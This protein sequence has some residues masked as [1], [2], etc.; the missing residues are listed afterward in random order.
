MTLSI[1]RTSN[2][3]TNANVNFCKNY[4][5]IKPKHI[6]LD[7]DFM[8]KLQKKRKGPIYA[9]KAFFISFKNFIE[10]VKQFD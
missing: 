5:R 6:V 10:T 3:N 1:N 4:N 8:P 2:L 7:R 9:V